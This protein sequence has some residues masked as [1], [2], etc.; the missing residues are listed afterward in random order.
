VTETGTS[1]QNFKKLS[2]SCHIIYPIE[3]ICLDACGKDSMPDNERLQEQN[4]SRILQEELYCHN[5]LIERLL[6]QMRLR[7]RYDKEE[8]ISQLF[9]NLS[10]RLNNGG[11]KIENDV[12][13][14]INFLSRNKKGEWKRILYINAYLRTMIQ[15][16]L[17]RLFNQE[18]KSEVSVSIETLE[19][20][21]SENHSIESSDF[22]DDEKYR[23]LKEKLDFLSLEDQRILELFYIENLSFEEIA[24]CLKS[25]GFPPDSPRPYND[26]SLRK[27]KQ[28]A[29]E[30]LRKL[31]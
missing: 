11:L 23:R 25:S 6:I 3:S 26:N 18:K 29:L 22:D 15:N 17:N 31:Y 12:D 28:R 21:E 24:Q 16:H 30:K 5:R 27:K 7:G 1:L 20:F 9:I 14:N 8:I 2:P 13:N 4:W 19:Y 10:N